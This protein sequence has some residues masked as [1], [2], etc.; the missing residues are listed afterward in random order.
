MTQIRLEE[1]LLGLHSGRIKMRPPITQL[2][3]SQVRRIRWCWGECV[4]FWGPYP[5][6]EQF[7]REI[8]R[9]VTPEDEILAWERIAQKYCRLQ[10]QHKD[11]GKLIDRLVLE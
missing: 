1:L 6:F 9:D 5:I 2:T 3:P 8:C 10:G 4:R 11:K 7:E